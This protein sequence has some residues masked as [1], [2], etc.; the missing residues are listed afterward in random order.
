MEQIQ[1]HEWRHFT[2]TALLT[3]IK[4]K[5]CKA[6]RAT[7]RLD[8]DFIYFNSLGLESKTEPACITRQL[9]APQQ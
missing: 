2:S 7:S 5:H 6:I 8:G 9:N 4:C 3:K 1:Q